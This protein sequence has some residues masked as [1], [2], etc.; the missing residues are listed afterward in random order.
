MSV[1]LKVFNGDRDHVRFPLVNSCCYNQEIF[2]EILAGVLTIV[3]KFVVPTIY[4]ALFHSLLCAPCM[5]PA[6]VS[7]THQLFQNSPKTENQRTD[8][9]HKGPQFAL[10]SCKLSK[11]KRVFANYLLI[12]CFS[13][14]LVQILFGCQQT[15][16][17]HEN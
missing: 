8:S 10:W 17:L 5:F 15:F 9:R 13:R 16:V 11:R 14:L 7:S 12:A 1:S 6:R 2:M 4:K 3:L